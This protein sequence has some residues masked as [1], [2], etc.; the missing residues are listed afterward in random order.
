MSLV[1]RLL[2]RARATRGYF[3]SRGRHT[4][5]VRLYA[6]WLD[7]ALTQLS[8]ALLWTTPLATVGLSRDE[9]AA[10]HQ[11]ARLRTVRLA[12]QEL[13]EASRDHPPPTAPT[14]ATEGS[15]HKQYLDILKRSV[16]AL[17]YL[18]QGLSSADE[19]MIR[20]ASLEL[21]DVATSA[22]DLHARVIEQT[23]PF[24]LDPQ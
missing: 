20:V 18:D 15:V 23:L 14:C 10:P 21:R 2:A 4:A 17:D 8:Q 6:R 12:L 16:A 3:T 5:D 13:C 19:G 1:G 24:L 7:S 9:V 22:A 11:L